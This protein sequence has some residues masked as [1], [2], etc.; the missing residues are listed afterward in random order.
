MSKPIEMNTVDV[1]QMYKDGSSTYDIA[2]KY[3]TNPNRVRRLL[4]KQG[5]KLRSK[6]QAQK[7]AI[8]TG[9]IEHPTKGRKRTKEEKLAIS[10][11]AVRYWNDMDDKERTKRRKQAEKSWNEMSDAKKED[12]RRKGLRQ[13]QKAAAEGSKLEREVQKFVSAAGYH[14][15]AHKKDL[16][17]QKKYEIDLYI[18][19]LRT[20]IEVDGL[21]HF[22]PIWGEEAFR[23]Q[24]EA[25]AKKDGVLLSRGFN[26]IRIE[27][28]TSSMAIAKLAALQEELTKA[29]EEIKEG[30]IDSQLKVITYE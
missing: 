30:T 10:A 7:N 27:N 4:N 22:S 23:K 24:V 21:S 5:V 8:E 26:L 17:P 6:S 20:I 12:M 13:I 3:G 11:S 25:D 9:K 28:K 18:P 16:I 14:F 29:L 15:Q 19:A 1:V 2:K